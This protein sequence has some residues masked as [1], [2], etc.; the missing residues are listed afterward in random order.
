M[1]EKE[2]YQRVKSLGID[3]SSMVRS[4]VRGLRK[5]YSFQEIFNAIWYFYIHKGVGTDKIDKYG[6]GLIRDARNMEEARK[7]FMSLSI[8][9]ERARSS[10][11]ES[12]KVQVNTIKTRR[13]KQKVRREEFD[14][15]E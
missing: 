6:I 12:K 9:R 4:Q 7:Y 13:Q 3:A 8:K 5:N 2:F 15:D 10:A 1:S 11:K 14:W